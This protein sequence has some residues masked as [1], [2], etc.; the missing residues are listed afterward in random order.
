MEIFVHPDLAAVFTIH[1][2]GGAYVVTR[3]N[4]DDP[5]GW[6]IGIL[7]S[8]SEARALADGGDGYALD[9]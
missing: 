6:E 3:Y 2:D 1:R 8:G 9:N 7:S 5:Q 4:A